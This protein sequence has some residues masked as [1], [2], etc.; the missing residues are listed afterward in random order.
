MNMRNHLVIFVKTPRLGK[1]KTRLARDIGAVAA[2]AF[3]RRTLDDVLRRLARDPRWQC[4]LAV[5]PDRD[6]R[7]ARLWPAGCSRIP[8]GTGA[9]GR[10]MARP[11]RSLSPGPVV[12]IGS[13][14]P[15]ITPGH[16]A[17]AFRALGDHD[18]A[19]GPGADGGYWLVGLRR[20]PRAPDPFTAV[21]W[22]TEHA[23]SDTLANLDGGTRVAMLEILEDI[24]DGQALVRWRAGRRERRR[25]RP[26]IDSRAHPPVTI[27]VDIIGRGCETAQ[28]S[29]PGHL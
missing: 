4:W 6:A 23:L 5:T 19:F 22:S 13:D 3:Y 11:M 29:G 14:I 18:A 2:A 26:H 28:R 10:R 20:R 25:R 12:I 8:Q 27:G 7:D 16:I 1:I 9:L 15:D 17:R 24:D 21:R